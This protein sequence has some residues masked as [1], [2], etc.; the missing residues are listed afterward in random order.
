MLFSHVCAFIPNMPIWFD[1]I[2]RLSMPIFIFCITWGIDYTKNGRAYGLRL[3][4]SGLIM[5][6]T[7][8]YFNSMYIDPYRMITENIFVTLF[9]VFLLVYLIHL[10]MTDKKK[11]IVYLTLFFLMQC[12]STFL[13]L[14][15][16][17]RSRMMA[18]IIAA[19]LPNL[20]YNEGS[21]FFVAFGIMVYFTKDNRDAFIK[22][23]TVF[24]ALWCILTVLNG[25]SINSF[26]Y[27][28][29]QWMM[30]GALPILLKYNH[31]KGISMKYFFY[32]FYPIHIYLLFMVG[33]FFSN[34]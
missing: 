25:F 22:A 28:Q 3:Y 18:D 8:Y 19:V 29:Y 9:L 5:G 11:G 34:L 7:N 2:G 30:I 26:F 16:L 10:L 13:Y 33:N 20:L 17:N 24:S 27:Q 6:I 23:Y 4:V 14:G 15:V 32:L 21:V 12:M 1:W 31:K